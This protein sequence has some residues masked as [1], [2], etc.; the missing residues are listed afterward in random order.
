MTYSPGDVL[1][2]WSVT[3]EALSPLHVGAGG[4]PLLADWDVVPDPR[5]PDGYLV[6]DLPRVLERVPP[7]RWERPTHQ[8]PT[9]W[10]ERGVWPSLARYT[11][12]WHPPGP[13][14][15]AP[16]PREIHPFTK[17]P[18]GAT[19]YLPGS[20]LKGALRS[21]LA[22]QYARPQQVAAALARLLERPPGRQWAGQE[23]EEALFGPTDTPRHHAPHT[24][25]LRTLHVGDLHPQGAVALELAL[26]QVHSLRAGRLEGKDQRSFTYLE[27]VPTDARFAG[28]VTVEGYPFRQEHAPVGLPSARR[29]DLALEGLRAALR[30]DGLARFQQEAR[31]HQEHG[32]AAASAWYQRA[33]RRVASLPPESFPLQLGWGPGWGSKAVSS[34]LLQDA[35]FARVRQEYRLGRGD[36]PFPKSRR[37]LVTPSDAIPLGWVVVTLAPAQGRGA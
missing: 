31:F 36:A 14:T 8:P 15:G 32:P 10:V 24:D 7:Q 27:V 13:P 1:E 18:D 26:A 25:L 4:P 21:A 6:L 5:R 9:A 2:R 19:P 11:L 23:L 35:S 28:A 33:L 37:L 17:G 30:R 16:P 20:S 12:V 34:L 22:R 3:V 29:P